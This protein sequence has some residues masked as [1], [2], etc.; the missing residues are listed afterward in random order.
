MHH[1]KN[2]PQP[3]PS[4]GSNWVAD[5]EISHDHAA[6]AIQHELDSHTKKWED[7]SVIARIRHKKGQKAKISC[8]SRWPRPSNQAP[9]LLQC[10]AFSSHLRPYGGQP[11]WLTDKGQNSPKIC[12]LDMLIQAENRVLWRSGS[13]QELL[14][15]KVVRGNLFSRWSFGWS[16]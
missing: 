5:H 8:I 15:N 14:W 10:F 11:F 4:L 9:L 2:R 16:T 3:I 6:R 13:R 12:W 7:G 1:L